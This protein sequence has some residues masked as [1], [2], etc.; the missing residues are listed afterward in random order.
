MKPTTLSDVLP[1]EPWQ[2]YI[3]VAAL[4]GESVAAITG[5][6]GYDRWRVKR[7]VARAFEITGKSLLELQAEMTPG[8][9]NRAIMRLLVA[10]YQELWPSSAGRI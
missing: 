1:L 7:A 9:S 8:M 4:R 3:I 6:K 5:R 2:F 10:H